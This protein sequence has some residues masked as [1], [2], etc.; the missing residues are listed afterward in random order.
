MPRLLLRAIA[1]RECCSMAWSRDLICAQP[2]SVRQGQLR[3]ILPEY[4]PNAKPQPKLCHWQY[5]CM[6][7]YTGNPVPQQL[8]P[9]TLQNEKVECTLELMPDEA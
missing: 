6:A 3:H 4:K 1:L 8:L 7:R 9:R 5:M 2:M